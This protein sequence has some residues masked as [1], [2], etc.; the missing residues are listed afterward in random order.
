MTT[1]TEGT[2]RRTRPCDMTQ[3][4]LAPL[5]PLGSLAGT[6]KSIDIVHM[7][8]K[9]HIQIQNAEGSSTH[10]KRMANA[11]KTYEDLP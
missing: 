1:E 8:D 10:G 3:R 6:V 11:A 9:W 5:A 7:P 4:R 2:A